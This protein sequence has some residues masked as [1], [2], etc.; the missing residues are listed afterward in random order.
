MR[1][2][3]AAFLAV[4]GLVL[5]TSA[6]AFA[7]KCQAADIDQ[8]AERADAVFL[9]T[10]EE[11]SEVGSRFE[12]S[13]TATRAYKGVVDR[14]TTVRSNQAT[15]ACGLGNLEVGSD[16]LF[17][18]TGDAPPFAASTCG[19]SGPATTARINQ[20]EKAL[21]S[22]DAVNPPPPPAPTMTKVEESAP[23]PVSRLAAPGGALVLVGFLGLLVV[24]RLARR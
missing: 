4:S 2:L 16:Y 21:G 20:V 1:V 14:T 11:V 23:A 18:V 8:Q 6:P 3:V 22:G 5:A 9:A 13:L 17:L 24:G 7:C 19:G 10:V 15:A 12:Y